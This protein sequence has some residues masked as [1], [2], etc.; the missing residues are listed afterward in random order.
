M[1]KTIAWTN[2]LT[3]L[4]LTALFLI[5]L[6]FIADLFAFP[7]LQGKLSP[8][9]LMPDLRSKDSLSAVHLLGEAGF[10]IG[11]ISHVH[12]D[13]IP[14]GRIV[15]QLPLAGE[16]VK[17]KRHVCFTLSLGRE[18]V[19]VPNLL[20]LSPSEAS[21]T[22]QRLGLHLGE[23]KEV[24][25]DR[26]TPG[27][28]IATVPSSG[29][30]ISRGSQVHITI[31]QNSLQGQTYV[32]D[33]QNIALEKAKAVLNKA[34][35]RLR[36]VTSQPSPDMLPNTVLSQSIKAGTRVDKGTFIDFIVSD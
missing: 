1:K 36:Q 26:M 10:K 24:V 11:Q 4:G 22:L 16:E 25:N 30:R 18:M 15:Y 32:P 19:M 31:S 6:L 20:E 27:A 12:N 8:K 28:I 34:S 29:K 23:T 13:S 17:K 5:L 2:L 7:F 14:L 35:L 21:D 3:L 9:V 33:C